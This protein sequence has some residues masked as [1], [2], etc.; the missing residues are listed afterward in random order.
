MQ[1]L[2]AIRESYAQSSP[3][4]ILAWA[5]E[6][7]GER[8]LLA[9]SFGAED[10]VLLHML[11]KITPK[12]RVF[13][14]DTGRLHEETY[15]VMERCRQRYRIQFEVYFPAQ[16]QVEAM[17]REK[18]A[19]SFYFSVEE[20]KSCCHIRK[21]E[22]LQRALAT[23]DAWITGLRRSQAVTRAGME[24]V[25]QD[26]TAGGIWKINPLAAWDEKDVWDYIHAHNIPYN[27]LH[28]KGFPSIGCAPCTR[29]I[30]P[31]EPIR[32][33]RWWWEAPE[34]KECGL[35]SAKKEKA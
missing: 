4:E 16:A 11:H 10:V 33:G 6:R 8:L 20:R 17:L 28:D 35:H 5:Y 12:P 30:E 19:Y 31:G 25:E 23:C 14:L 24:I 7:F 29:A 13:V 21:V 18:G 2:E 34:D 9:C 27:K 22:P 15:D 1:S 32:A 3:E 26:D